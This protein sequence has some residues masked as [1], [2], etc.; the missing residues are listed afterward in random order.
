MR[1]E[2]GRIRALLNALLVLGILAVAAFGVAQVARRHWQWQ[3][4]FRAR[5]EFA[6][7]GGLE[8]GGK[9]RVQGM[10]AG[11]VES[12]VP[13]TEPGCPVTLVMRIDARLKSLVRSDAEARIGTQGVV[14]A[15]VVEIIPGKPDAPALAEGGTIKSETPLELTDLLKNASNSLER[16]NSVAVDA[17]R[18]LAEVNAIAASVRQGKGSLGRLVQD[19]AAYERL[20]ALSDQGARTLNDLEENLSALK[21]TWPLSRYFNER[22][23]FDR[24]RVLFHPGSERESRTL[25]ES[26]LFE[27]GRAVLTSMGRQR[28]D[29]IA[30]WF[31]RLRRPKSAEL[32]IAS[33]TD[34]VS[35]GDDLA[36][37]LTQ[38]Q[39]EAVR[40]YL[41]TKHAI[42]S[43]GWFNSRRKIAAVGFGAETPRAPAGEIVAQPRRRIEIIIFTPQA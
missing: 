9:V 20:V 32:V 27:P 18:G 11:V 17:Q 43:N 6:S 26:D 16:L 28:L 12:I 36:L 10:D 29:E 8:P 38:E 15:K 42:D 39:A 31:T 4:T 24:D 33:F 2:I 5:A 40:K 21:R 35:R 30:Q 22:A 23:F 37:F 25:A 41:V 3:A 1:R 19:E 34:D 13:P 14:G 7:I